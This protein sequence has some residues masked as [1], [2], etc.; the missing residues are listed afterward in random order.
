MIVVFVSLFYARRPPF[1][2]RFPQTS[3]KRGKKGSTIKEIVSGVPQGS[4]LG[5]LIIII[6]HL[7]Q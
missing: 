3:K 7:H 5:P 2:Q 1:I 4:I 6:P